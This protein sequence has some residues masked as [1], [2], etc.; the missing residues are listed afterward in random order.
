MRVATWVASLLIVLVAFGAG[1]WA[2]SVTLRSPAPPTE[3][4]ASSLLVRVEEQTVGRA[5]TLNV[6]VTQPQSAVATNALAGVVTTVSKSGSFKNGDVLYSVA[7]EPVRVVKGATPFYRDLSIGARGNDVAQLRDALNSLGYLKAPGGSMFDAATTTALKAWQSALGTTTTGTVTLG[8]LVA[9]PALPA[10]LTLDS[11]VLQVGSVVAGGERVVFSAT[12][13]P[14]FRL[15][16]SSEQAKLIPQ[17]AKIEIDHADKT[18]Q[19]VISDSGTDE[20]QQVVFQLVAASGGAVCGTECGSLASNEEMYL[21]AKVQVVPPVT[22]PA[23][24][25]AAITTDAGGKATVQVV[26]SGGTL[27]TR[28]VTI[29]GSQDG[30]AIVEGV[31][32]GETVRVLGGSRPATANGSAQPTPGG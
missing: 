22:G 31:A 32:V 28:P 2:A 5:L 7:G 25:V 14:S 6:T 17:D 12:G 19:A 23:V 16:V 9:V 24:P 27:E 10:A 26:D 30:V 8:E 20:Q 15:V 29:L 1:F 11:K 13:T 3:V 21:L 4:A 18:W